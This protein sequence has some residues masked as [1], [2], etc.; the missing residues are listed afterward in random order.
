MMDNSLAKAQSLGVLDGNSA[1]KRDSLSKRDRVDFFKFTLNRSSNVNFKLAGLRSNADLLLLNGSGGTIARSAKGGN[2]AEKVQQQLAAGTYYVQ[3]KGKGGATGY[4]LKGSAT[5]VGSGGSVPAP[6]TGTRNNPIDLGTLTSSPVGRS[7]DTAALGDGKT[8][9]YKFQLG[10]ISDVNIRL[11]QV[12]GSGI[13]RLHYDTNRNGVFDFSENN[14]VDVASGSES[15]NE[16][17]SQVLP[18]TGTYFMEMNSDSLSS[19]VQYDLTVTPTPAPGNLPTDPGPEESTAYNL[20]TLNRGG[21]IE[22]KDYV[23]RVDETDTYRFTLGEAAK[24]TYNK[25][26]TAGDV[27]SVSST[28]FYDKNNNGLMD[29]NEVVFGFGNVTTASV[30]LQSGNYFLST[31]GANTGGAA[32]SLTLAAS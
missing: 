2:K 11:S 6:G 14:A 21:Q 13:V 10:Q 19:N 31:K 20:G 18:A 25:T 27:F 1:S 32:Y 5:P 3:V 23:G 16:P 28:L 17:A 24:L 12:T 26:E 30:S 29:S 9:F 22:A 4:K 8:K 7:Q 15:R